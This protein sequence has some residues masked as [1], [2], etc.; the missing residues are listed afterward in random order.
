MLQRRTRL[1]TLLLA[2]T[3][4]MASAAPE[5]N[6]RQWRILELE[7]TA[8]STYPAP[9]LDVDLTGVF[10]GPAGEEFKMPGFWDGGRSWKIRFTPTAPGNWSYRT[11]CNQT[12]DRGLHGK[13]GRFKALPA[14]GDNPLYLHG[15]I[16]RVSENKRHL[17]YSDGT[18]FFWLG[19][20]WWTTPSDELA[21]FDRSTNPND[22]SG[23]MFKTL[24]DTRRKQGYTVAQWTFGGSF[25]EMKAPLIWR[26]RQWKDENMNAWRKVDR[27]FRYANDSGILPVVGSYWAFTYFSLGLNLEDLRLQWKY[28]VSRYGAFATSWLICGEYNQEPPVAEGLEER[29]KTA[30]ALGA[31]IKEFDPYHRAM[32][33]HPRGSWADKRQVWGQPWYDFIMLQGGHFKGR[34]TPKISLYDSAYNSTPRR[35]VL[36]AECRYEGIWDTAEDDVRHAAYRAVQSGSFGFTYG[37]QGLYHAIAMEPPPK[38]ISPLF[39]D[40]VKWWDALAK[41][42]GNEMG[43]LR[44]CYESV[45]WWKLEPKPGAVTTATALDDPHQILTKAD[46][47]RV[48]LI[49]FPRDLQPD[50]A[51]TLHGGAPAKTYTA[52]WF[53]PRTGE[54]AVVEKRLRMAEGRYDLPIRSDNKDW[55]LIVK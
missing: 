33:V 22:P 31:F 20:T 49:Y 37:A 28:I 16:L 26:P 15:G 25:D 41:P 8:A 11:I 2:M 46:G 7:F 42:G 10:Q 6:A 48:F 55:M 17:T 21:P 39:G 29:L 44:K 53:N 36:E 47:D 3:A 35:P 30:F 52:T 4:T 43:Y 27:Y 9:L 18:S 45:E 19:D 50:L 51:A 5:N 14:A 40:P 1:L 34:T 12:R 54:T 13:S 23:S 24:I 38:F 32:S